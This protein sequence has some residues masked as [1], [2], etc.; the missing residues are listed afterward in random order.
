MRKL[1]GCT[2]LIALFA[3]A[4]GYA[5]WTTQ[6]DVGHYLSDLRI[7]LAINE[8]VNNDRGNLL[9]I[10]PD[11]SPRDYQSLALVHLKLAAYLNSARDA[12]LINGKTVVVLPEHIGSWLMFSGEKNQLYQAA[13]LNQAMH[14]LA[15]SNPLAFANAWLRADGESRVND[16]HLRMKA[17]SMA[18]DYQTLFGGL[19]KEF[20]V[21]L[22]AGSIAL[23]DPRIEH[24]KLLVGTGALYNSSVVFDR[25]GA[26]IGTPQ[27]QLLPTYEE[28]SYIQ[29]SPDHELNVVDTPA[30]RLGILIGSDS[31]YPENYRTLN[32]KGA[33]LIAVPAFIVGK[34]TWDKPWGGYKSVS[35]PSEISLKPGEVTEGDAWHRLTFTSS[36][37][38]STANA[39]VTV[40]LRG[41][42]WDKHS[43]G[44]G[45]IS[46]NGQTSPDQPGSGARLLN[47]WL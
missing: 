17:N 46:R 6:R 41:K 36:L 26:A 32:E 14:W 7:E 22:V 18:D 27:R 4:G 31:W 30:G 12:G 33:Q 35:T 21:T 23:P 9:G 44:Q 38:I 25:E 10:E 42:F 34:T 43:T 1:I 45:F 39:G 24:G 28:Q 16:A 40:F 3:A 29:P 47:L 37:P 13:N 5:W 20:G 8:G 11:L 15:I 2:L 19:A